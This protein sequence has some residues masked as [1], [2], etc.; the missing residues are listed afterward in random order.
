ML[1]I[2]AD[3]GG[4]G[5]RAALAENG[6]VIAETRLEGVTDRVRAV[7][8]LVKE[9]MTQTGL[10]KVDALAVGATGFAM[11]G[12]TLRHAA[13]GFPARHVL[14]CSDMVSSYA[15]ALGLESGAVVAAGTGAVALG[16]DGDGIWRRVDGWGHLLGD[17][18]GGSWIGRMALQAALRAADGRTGG[19]PALLSALC[20]HFG[21][22]EELVA[23]L[24]ARDDRAGMMAGFVPLVVEAG[25]ETSRAILAQAGGHLAETALAALVGKR[26]VSTTGNL[27]QVD[28]VR[29]AF[30][31]ALGAEV[32]T[33][34]AKGSS[35]EG[36]LLL[37]HAAI[38]DG[39]PAGIPCEQFTAVP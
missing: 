11:L 33:V 15:G 7:Q 37:A 8:L 20:K 32:E 39:L 1:V 17:L 31:A 13:T 25:D 4:T 35:V 28:P 24:N 14:L 19:S 10:S 5:A 30:D 23:A 34:R 26:L 21:S 36:A 2:G 22:P 27:F 3:L 38:K 6:H 9:L 29:A 16:F 12:A 18:G